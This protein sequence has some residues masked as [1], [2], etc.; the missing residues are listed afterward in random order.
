MASVINTNV[1]S[2][3]AQ[4]NLGMSQSSLSTTLQRLSSGLRIN[5]AKDDAAGLAISQRM[6][7]QIRG[8]NQAVRNAN[9]GIS[10]AQT[11]EGALSSS[12]DML[13]RIRELA[14]QSA[15]A[16]NSAS[17]RKAIQAEV[18]NLLSEL[19]R[20]S[21]TT[22][23][24]G[25]KLLDG[26]F[27]SATFQVGANANQTITATTGNFRT[28]NYGT[29]L[30]ESK[31]VDAAATATSLA[32]TVV[33]DG[34]QSK[35]VTLTAS[36]TAG[37]AA[38]AIN[39]VSDSTGVTASARTVTQL[40]TFVAGGSYSLAVKGDN[41]TTAANITFSVS[42]NTAS[43]LA[44]AV[45]AF[46]NASSTTGITAKLNTSNT[47]IVL[48][49]EAGAN[50]DI[51]NNSAAAGTSFNMYAFDAPT[52]LTSGT[53][54]FGA[55]LAVAGAGGTGVAEG[56]VEM[57]SNK[58]F[59]INTTSTSAMATTGASSLNAV[60]TI[61]VS[62][63]DGSTMALKIIDSALATVNGQRASFGALQSRF[64]NTVSNLQTTSENLS[65]S[66]SRIQDTDFAAE[67]A[68][69]SRTQV[70]QQAG[71]AMLAQ[72]NALPNTVL[73]LLK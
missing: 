4:R 63:V 67:T 37:S 19:D 41:T 14:V 48:T 68:N 43:G 73:S 6:T 56:T 7:S 58:G 10:L 72:A 20:V 70:L 2:L 55:A 24:N 38:A 1:A 59:S 34:L 69:L 26:T 22:E 8:L 9:D 11:A 25:Q 54:S 18:G 33:I 64:E 36:D 66:R 5:S 62:T 35:T 21:Q 32:G 51:T 13:Q 71:V 52:T 60:N 40:D 27:G 28:N 29:N 17:D 61:D 12:G 15:N 45:S 3:N 16:S 39:A 50:V 42:A 57:S 31:L 23:F 49:N 30:N 47:G 46:N 65:A 53:A 44:E